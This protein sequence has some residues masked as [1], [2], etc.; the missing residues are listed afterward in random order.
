MIYAIGEY[1]WRQAGLKNKAIRVHLQEKVE[2]Y[3]CLLSPIQSRIRPKQQISQLAS[4]IGT[5][6]TV[7]VLYAKMSIED[8][9]MISDMA[10]IPSSSLFLGIW[11]P[12]KCTTFYV[13]WRRFESCFTS[14]KVFHLSNR[15]ESYASSCSIILSIERYA[16]WAC[17]WRG[18]K[19]ESLCRYTNTI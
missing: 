2:T 7:M 18:V 8:D 9:Y 19:L 13:F 6:L 12:K 1:K 11:F 10:N 3:S 16:F 15:H 5:G 4:V 14:N 17:W